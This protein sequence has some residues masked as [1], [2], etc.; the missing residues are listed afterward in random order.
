MTKP[1]MH[2]RNDGTICIHGS[3]HRIVDDDA[4]GDGRYVLARPI[5]LIGNTAYDKLI[6]KDVL[7]KLKR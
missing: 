1:I 6:R 7:H 3:D 5:G 2:V 4:K